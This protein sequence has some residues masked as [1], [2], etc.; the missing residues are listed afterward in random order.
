MPNGT[1]RLAVSGVLAFATGVAGAQSA[2]PATETLSAGSRQLEEIIVTARKYEENL[3]E[4]PVSVTAFSS[5]TIDKLGMTGMADIALRTPGLAYGNFGDTKLS[6]TSLRGVVAGASSAGQDPAVG[7]YVD[8]VF[9]GQGADAPLDLYDI[10][11]VEVLRGPQG[12]LYGRNTIGGVVSLTTKRPTDEFEAST[13]L[14]YGNFD[15][16]RVGGS[17]S[18]PLV[19]D[20]LKGKIAAVYNDRDGTSDNVWL[21]IPVNDQ[22]HWTTRGQLLFTP[23]DTTELLV[24]ADYFDI[25]QHPLVFETLRYNDAMLLPQLLDAFELPRNADPFDRKVYASDESEETLEA[26]SASAALKMRFGNVDFTSITA[27]RSHEYFSRTDTDRSPVDMAYDGDPEDVDTLSEEVRFAWSTG[28]FDWLVGAYYFDRNSSNFSFIELGPDLADLF[29]APEIAGLRVGSDAEIG[30]TSLSGFASATWRAS[31]QLDFTLGGRYTHEKKDIDYVQTDPLGLLGGSFSVKADDTW[32]QFTPNASARYRFS[33]DL[34]GYATISQGFKSGGF[35]D[36]LGDANGIG[37]DPETV[38]NYEIGF[39]SEFM[40]RRVLTNVALYYMD[41]S[42]IQLTNDNPATPIYDPIILNAG[43]AHSAGI[44]AEIQAAATERLML[45]ATLSIQEAEYDEGTLPTGEPLKRIPF[46]PKYTGN[47]NAE[48]RIPIGSGEL[49]LLGEVILRGDS[50]LTQDNQAD[51]FVDDY[52]LY[53]ARLNY[54]SASGTWN[55]TL[56]GKNL[57]DEDVKQRLFDLLDQDLIGQNFI[58][59]ADPRTYGVTLRMD[60]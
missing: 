41:W 45:G 9:I 13:E 56:W 29:G 27:Y 55:I 37:Y 19:P 15:Y 57:S 6:P 23:S 24:T 31:D 5:A 48:Y 11:R 49:S 54:A 53:N 20:V 44:E 33:P 8:E 47:L 16:V 50:Y 18:G 21:D 14:T 59:L 51:G 7:V 60:F 28:S 30:T 17:L 3:Q 52:A 58:V 42:D 1:L 12:T 39:K 34:M 2:R 22:H 43:K 40:D 36:G 38:W 46:A 32:S 26:W 25:D 35:N 4:T 10:E